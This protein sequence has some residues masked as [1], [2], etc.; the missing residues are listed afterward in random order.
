M[1]NVWHLIKGTFKIE[2]LVNPDDCH[3]SNVSAQVVDYDKYTVFISLLS[4]PW[5][6][7]SNDPI[8]LDR[9]ILFS[10]FL[11]GSQ[12]CFCCLDSQN[13]TSVLECLQLP[14]PFSTRHYRYQNK[15]L[16]YNYLNESNIWKRYMVIIMNKSRLFNFRGL[17]DFQ[18]N[19]DWAIRAFVIN[20]HDQCL[21]L[22]FS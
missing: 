10:I 18:S 5:Y 2:T 14:R 4:V 7:Q 3:W 12:Y 13:S 21:V 11:N 15:L 20:I 6:P 1:L 17:D 19:P 8:T 16:S 9:I 22:Y